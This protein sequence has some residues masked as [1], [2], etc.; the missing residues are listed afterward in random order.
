[1][2]SLHHPRQGLTITAPTQK[3]KVVTVANACLVFISCSYSRFN[4]LVLTG[5]TAINS[6]I[7][8][9]T[10]HANDVDWFLTCL[11]DPAVIDA[12]VEDLCNLLDDLV[13]QWAA[14]VPE[15]YA[16]VPLAQSR[17]VVMHGRVPTIK[18]AYNRVHVCDITLVSPAMSAAVERVLPR[19]VMDVTVPMPAAGRLVVK[20]VSVEEI[21]H[22][23]VCTITKCPTVDE[24]AVPVLNGWRIAKDKHRLLRLMV[25]HRHGLLR[26]APRLWVLDDRLV[27]GDGDVDVSVYLPRLRTPQPAAP[28]PVAGQLLNECGQAEKAQPSPPVLPVMPVMHSAGIASAFMDTT[29]AMNSVFDAI[30]GRLGRLASRVTRVSARATSL[31]SLRGETTATATTPD[32][33]V[34]GRDLVVE[35][36]STSMK[37]DA[38]APAFTATATAMAAARDAV[39]LA[40]HVA[41]TQAEARFT[42][43]SARA[44]ALEERLENFKQT[45]ASAVTRLVRFIAKD[46]VADDTVKEM[47]RVMARC[48]QCVIDAMGH[49]AR[50]VTFAEREAEECLRAMSILRHSLVFDGTETPAISSPSSLRRFVATLDQGA[51]YAAKSGVLPFAACDFGVCEAPAAAYPPIMAPVVGAEFVEA[52]D[53]K[54][55]NSALQS[56]AETLHELLSTMI[57]KT[58]GIGVQCLAAGRRRAAEEECR[59]LV[60]MMCRD[61]VS[62]AMVPMYDGEDTL[63][64]ELRTVRIKR[65]GHSADAAEVDDKFVVTGNG[66]VVKY[67]KEL[68]YRREASLPKTVAYHE[69]FGDTVAPRTLLI[70]PMSRTE[71]TMVSDMANTVAGTVVAGISQWLVTV[72]ETCTSVCTEIRTRAFASR[73]AG[74]KVEAA[75]KIVASHREVCRAFEGRLGEQLLERQRRVQRLLNAEAL[76]SKAFAPACIITDPPGNSSKKKKKKKKK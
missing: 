65:D 68:R 33:T 55:W 3:Q 44:A 52:Q 37:D 60:A 43:V 57:V 75:A 21:L 66:T 72:R 61:G 40:V 5:S 10:L 63:R 27:E 49:S 67:L 64:F 2:S 56:G 38:T 11:H 18:L 25:L 20:V 16:C 46:V 34:R 36:M 69:P 29:R 73:L 12:C 28:A 35:T 26:T 74:D 45:C 13:Q 6:Y 23:I 42:A 7:D 19:R 71:A 50:C 32:N 62:R 30:E 47:K 24:F 51:G 15:L 9:L 8:L 53:A 14:N 4:T 17:E 39:A 58:V 48:S 31:R 70:M 54:A 41:T 1:M 59:T 76:F 22:R